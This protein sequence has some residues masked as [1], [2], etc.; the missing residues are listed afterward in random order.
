MNRRHYDTVSALRYANGA[1]EYVK[2]RKTNNSQ[3]IR[4]LL[5][6]KKRVA[7]LSRPKKTRCNYEN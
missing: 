2:T 4:G 1:L 3:I 7:R 6:Y 5:R